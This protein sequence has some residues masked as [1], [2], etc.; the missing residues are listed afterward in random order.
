MFL[1]YYFSSYILKIN[2]F[3]FN[4]FSAYILKINIFL[5]IYNKKQPSFVVMAVGSYTTPSIVVVVYVYLKSRFN[6]TF[7]TIRIG[8]Q[9]S[10]YGSS[11]LKL[12]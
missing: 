8:C 9:S 11:K 12:T 2:K 6:L 7:Q 10:L 3:K 4:V 1:F 5:H